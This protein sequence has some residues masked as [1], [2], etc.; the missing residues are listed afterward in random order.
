MLLLFFLVIGEARSRL[1]LGVGGA[2]AWRD[3]GGGMGVHGGASGSRGKAPAQ[4]IRIY[5]SPTSSPTSN[6]SS[7]HQK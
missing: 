5:T 4:F 3:I 2:G 6:L 7:S 1:R